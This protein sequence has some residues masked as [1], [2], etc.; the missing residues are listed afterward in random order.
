[1]SVFA[2]IGLSCVRGERLV[3]R[4]LDFRVEAGT[5][6]TLLG[7]NGAGKSSLLRLM[8]G[9]VAPVA[10]QMRWDDAAVA[11]DPEAHRA[12]LRWLGHGDGIKAGLTAAENAAFW[13]ALA[14]PGGLD[15]AA[16]LDRLGL[17]GV[18]DTPA[19]YLSQGQRRRLAL[20]RLL[21]GRAPLW[22]LDEPTVGLDAASVA[23]VEAMLD[24]HCRDGGLAVLATHVP[25]ATPGARTL[26][27][28][29]AGP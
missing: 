15:V 7:P 16:A 10:G 20:T 11:D 18:A 17:D 24:R 28:G 14:G 4:D 8:A 19:R 13:G 9:L 23:I 25:I 26:R 5:A 29:P 21:L 3:F 6:L 2:G 1:M 22:L 27:L 12:R